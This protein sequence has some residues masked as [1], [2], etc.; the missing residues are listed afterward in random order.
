MIS[1][2]LAVILPAY[3][4]A[5]TIAATIEAFHTELPQARIIV[6]NNN[7]KDATHQ[8]AADTLAKLAIDGEVI[9]EPR[10]G[11]GNAVR[12]AFL[13]ID[14]DA[15]VLADADLTYPAERVHD[16]LRPVLDGRADMVVGDRHSG[17][18]YATENKRP[19]HNFGNG[20]VQS[21]VNI[22]FGA[23]LVDIMSGYRVFSRS[24]VKTYPILVE[25]F[26]I[27]TDVTLHAL[28][29][30]LR[31]IEIPVEYKDRPEGSVSKLNTFSDGARV[32]FTI[33]QILRYYRPLAFFVAFSILFAVAGLV[34]AVPV[35]ED[36]LTQSYIT[37]IPLAI[38]A[39]ALETVAVLLFAIGIIL[40]SIAHHEKQRAELHYL[41]V[42]SRQR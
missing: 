20:L 28:Y 21:L 16:L 31:I 11:K 23:S 26:Q 25:G 3:N 36:W 40:D 37:H 34:A 41:A 4:E 39:A 24:F 1:P 2:K 33:A 19:L 6:V 5:Q 12:R 35:F 22:L 13:D 8:I 10:Q 7:S 27:E 18:H 14:A 15:Y 29:R 30:R 32:I 38:L 17:G 9:D 42:H